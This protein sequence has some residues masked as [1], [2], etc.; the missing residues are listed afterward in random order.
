[1]GLNERG[2]NQATVFWPFQ[3]FFLPNRSRTR[4][5]NYLIFILKPWH[6]LEQ[7]RHQYL[8]CNTTWTAVLHE[9]FRQSFYAPVTFYWQCW[10]V[11]EGL[12]VRQIRNLAQNSPY[13]LR[14]AKCLWT[15]SLADT[16]TEEINKLNCGQ[17]FLFFSSSSFFFGTG[18]LRGPGRVQR[19]DYVPAHTAS[20]CRLKQFSPSFWVAGTTGVHHHAS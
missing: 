18:S 16:G 6:Y 2:T 5:I 1:M 13:F 15:L 8:S 7:T 17:I 11:H 3:L 20:T 10:A 12:Q 9:Q 14:N 19:R 4:S